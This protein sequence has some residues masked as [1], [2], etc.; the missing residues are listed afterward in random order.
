MHSSSATRPH[1][2]WQ[3]GG[4]GL[5]AAAVALLS[6]ALIAGGT[7]AATPASA[8]VTG[9]ITGIVTSAKT[10]AP[11]EG[12]SVT[13][14]GAFDPLADYNYVTSGYTDVG[15]RYSFTRVPAGDYR[16][17][18]DDYSEDWD[19]DYV[20][21]LDEEYLS[22]FYGGEPGDYE[23]N[24]EPTTVGTTTRTVDQALTIG[25]K[26]T[27]RVLTS[28][29]KP[30]AGVDVFATGEEDLFD[31]AE[32]TTL[33]NGTF[34]LT[35]LAFGE[36]KIFTYPT[37][38]APV[39]AVVPAALT[40]SRP[41]V[42]VPTITQSVGSF[43]TGRVLT[44]E[45]KP[46]ADVSISAEP[47]SGAITLGTYLTGT[48][49]T[50]S[51]GEYKVG[52]L[53]PGTYAPRAESFGG[54]DSSDEYAV[55][56]L[57][58]SRD[59]YLA[60]T[61]SITKPGS[62]VTREFR[63]A[64]KTSL[65]G[66]VYTPAGVRAKNVPVMAWQLD[67]T[68]TA[69]EDFSAEASVVT[70]SKG[71]YEIDSLAPGSYVAGFGLKT[72]SSGAPVSRTTVLHS[73]KNTI[74]TRLAA[75]TKVTGK[76]T[77]SSGAALK[78]VEVTAIPLDDTE[79][80]E[81]GYSFRAEDL[82]SPSV[83]SATGSY[84]I[85]LPAGTW[86]LRFTDPAGRVATSYLGGGTSPT[87]EE[88]TAI[89]TTA[90]VSTVTG[91]NA[92]LSTAGA[93]VSAY[94]HS[95]SGAEDIYG[96][97][98]VNRV[99]DGEIVG[100][101]SYSCGEFLD[102]GDYFDYINDSFP[103]NKLADG[104]YRVT[105]RPSVMVNGFESVDTIV[106]FTVAG[107]AVTIIDGEPATDGTSLGDITLTAPTMATVPD[108]IDQPTVFAPDGTKVGATL[109]AIVDVA[110]L[111]PFWSSYHWLR[112]GRPIAGATSENY[113]VQ[114]GD[115][116]AVLTFEFSGVVGNTY[117]YPTI[118][119]PSAVVQ[120]AVVDTPV[121]A[122]SISGSARVGSTLT[123]I[124]APGD[125]KGTTY[126]YQ[127]NINGRPL[128]FVTTKTFS[129]RIQ[130]LSETLSVTVTK[131]IAGTATS[132]GATSAGVSIGKGKAIVLSKPVLRVNG[133]TSVKL[134]LGTTLS[135][136]V[137]GLPKDSV[138]V[139]YQWQVYRGATWASIPGATNGTFTLGTTATSIVK[140]G[141]RYRVTVS[142]ERSGYEA[143]TK[144]TSK[145]LKAYKYK[146]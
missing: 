50:N 62:T 23:G 94:V 125:P 67:G 64:K 47:A 45:G 130:E 46:A 91:Q 34:T 127:W 119:A 20:D 134:R 137:G 27:G 49:L 142:V 43:L 79:C 88:T 42:K 17:L 41:T 36:W 135:A 95:A 25:G 106:D 38:T 74:F 12:I 54:D 63:L 3:T 112:N 98:S 123:A 113:V 105:I 2:L 129:P 40:A 35:G 128:P 132:T 48:S 9:R 117:I 56:Y 136:S 108:V 60:R 140:A 126:G 15:G 87:A 11:I 120:D 78:G 68:G 141:Y 4:L 92:F 124:P 96:G 65:S 71:Q 116:G 76:V 139:S 19:E 73:G 8:A 99:I 122:P 146:K 101:P 58:G 10:G 104:D 5:R 85:P 133:K 75:I 57:G 32:T 22:Q 24:V 26:Y 7:I 80:P 33:S 1:F 118:S 31:G 61:V 39:S 107:G 70:N 115:I 44:A 30:A 69:D 28:A 144:V 97:I 89:T 52:P 6:L 90:A 21:P 13:L 59:R 138:G 86:A 102:F 84:S 66:V 72:T 82:G 53:L 109:T 103:L 114:R 93:D 14:L 16:V 51:K 29:G 145:S 18:F 110:G 55:E 111:D 81:G 131:T 77:T 143:S 37:K 100:S 121:D 83:T